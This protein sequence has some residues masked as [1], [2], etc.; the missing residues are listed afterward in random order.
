MS[1]ELWEI[2]AIIA[3]VV[4]AGIVGAVIIH[5]IIT[6]DDIKKEAIKKNLESV[7]I[8]EVNKAKNIVK[9][10]TLENQKETKIK[11]TGI[12]DDIKEG[13]VIYIK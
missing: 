4:V 7:I 9:F 6:K 13:D 1:D 5:K 3:G 8:K 11:G 2:L 12:S 10:S